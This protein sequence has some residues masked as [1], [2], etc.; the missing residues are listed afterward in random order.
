[1]DSVEPNWTVADCYPQ[2]R[3]TKDEVDFTMAYDNVNL[4]FMTKLM[5]H[6]GFCERMSRLI[7]ISRNQDG[8]TS[9]VVLNGGSTWIISI[10]N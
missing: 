2:D 8:S 4:S 3:F 6:M 5:P 7:C 10:V 9:H 1:M